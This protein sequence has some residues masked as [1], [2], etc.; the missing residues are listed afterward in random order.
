MGLPWPVRCVTPGMG[1]HATQ[2][3]D[4]P[5]TVTIRFEKGRPITINSKTVTMYEAIRLA[6]QLGGKH[7]V[8]ICYH[9]VENRF[10]G[11][12]SRGVY[13]APA[14]SCSALRIFTYCSL[15]LTVGPASCSINCH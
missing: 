13:E 11:I 12:K 5:E 14:W 6:N 15:S 10:V 3:P 8:G 4:K 2:A 9:L 7:G 1:V